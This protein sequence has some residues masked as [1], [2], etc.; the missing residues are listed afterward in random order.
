VRYC[1]A[2]DSLEYLFDLDEATGDRRDSGRATQCKIHYSF[3]PDA[4]TGLLY[5]ATH[6]SGPPKGDRFYN[7]WASWHDPVKA[8]RGAYLVAYDTFG[9][10]VR[11][12]ELMIPREG[13]RCL[14]FDPTRRRLYAVTYPRDHLVWYD[15]ERKALHDL[16]RLGSVNTQC[17]FSDHRGR[18]HTFIDSG[19]LVR[20]DPECDRLEQL[21]WS[22]PHADCQPA[23]HGVLYDAVCEPETG[24]VYLIPWKSRAH[25]ARFWPDDGEFGRLEDLGQLTPPG[26]PYQPTGVN[27]DH[28]GGLVF[29]ADG[30]LHYVKSKA[31]EV[32]GQCVRHGMLCRLDTSTLQHEELCTVQ[33]GNGPNYYVARAARDAE[34]SLYFGKILAEPAGFYRVSVVNHDG[35]AGSAPPI[36]RLWG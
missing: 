28:V 29:A 1:H 2:T 27:Q 4:A 25:L 3:A 5:C 13:C 26:D 17:L 30:R 9:D 7:P 16:G 6:L 24:A 31:I 34:G 11:E 32:D 19:R 20:Y 33:G 14:C 21:P 35:A 36:P 8:F 10:Q 23:W 12:V 22:Y 18:I 15:L